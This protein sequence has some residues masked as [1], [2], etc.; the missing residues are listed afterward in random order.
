MIRIQCTACKKTLE[1]DET[2]LSDREA[3]VVRCP[4]CGVTLLVDK[5]K[6]TVVGPDVRV[7]ADEYKPLAPRPSA[8]A[9]KATAPSSMHVGIVNDVYEVAE[10]H[11]HVKDDIRRRSASLSALDSGARQALDG[12]RVNV[13]SRSSDAVI[14]TVTGAPNERSLDQQLTALDAY[15]QASRKIAD[16]AAG[17]WRNVTARHRYTP[18][19]EWQ[20]IARSVIERAY[21]AVAKRDRALDPY[22]AQLQNVQT[23]YEHLVTRY[24]SEQV[25]HEEKIAATKHK[26]ASLETECSKA[27]GWLSQL[28]G[29]AGKNALGALPLGGCLTLIAATIIAAMIGSATRSG[30]VGWLMFFL[31]LAGGIW[32]AWQIGFGRNNSERSQA[33]RTLGDLRV[34][35]S[36]AAREQQETERALELHKAATPDIT[37]PATSWSLLTSSDF[38]SETPLRAAE[39]ERPS[40]QVVR[41]DSDLDRAA[42]V[43][44]VP[45]AVLAPA[46]GPAQ[47]AG[48]GA[49]AGMT[50]R[51]V[52]FIAP[53][54][55]AAAAA[56]VGVIVPDTSPDTAPRSLEPAEDE[57][58]EVTDKRR[59]LTIIAAI[60]STVIV[61][62]AYLIWSSTFSYSARIHK[63][64]AAGQ[65]FAPAGA[66]VYDLYKSEYAKNP[67]SSV[68]ARIA[69]K[70]RAVL[71]PAAE[72][73]FA[74]WYRDSDNTINWEEME[75]SCEF[76]ALVDPEAKVHLMRRSYAIA[77]Q[78]IE[79]RDFARALSSYEDA[80][81]LDPSWALALNGIGKVYMIESSPLF[82]ERL[83]VAYYERAA[84][85][86]PQFT[87]AV[88]N[89]GD[90]A[91][92]KRDYAGAERY[93]RQALATSPQRP[94]IL[95][96][97]GQVCRKT[98]RRAEAVRYYQQ[99]L[100]LEKDP[101]K[102]ESA[103]KAIAAI[104]NGAG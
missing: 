59:R 31:A 89:L 22:I 74:R 16:L 63:A 55:S 76:L 10:H 36:A 39:A 41:S 11:L 32:V 51:A 52:G 77:Q 42:T 93:L 17:I 29:T 91:L 92:R 54:P 45:A 103:M 33:T 5:R 61:V 57:D 83:G 65:I 1:A 35:Q 101:E 24:R 13:P 85:A 58:E 78:S 23:Q 104:Q 30:G 64:L 26:L 47:H 99:S 3:S 69:P 46:V 4:S 20:G 81:K 75:R 67:R 37:P 21:G 100:V 80:L 48:G 62:I 60:A 96:A 7:A 25:A 84:T 68:L 14:R 71:A 49:A 50:V 19:V 90:Y 40:L 88:K 28:E 12:L 95:R 94:S 2:T 102:I 82:N 86:D 70:V 87:W 38:D 98:G 43:V 9:L 66:S 56:G 97:L 73:A 44:D 79:A 8:E 18:I 27:Q 6:K 34:N 15:L 72:D 53:P